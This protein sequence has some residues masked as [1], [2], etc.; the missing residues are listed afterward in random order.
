DPD[1]KKR[2]KEI[3]DE[4]A[5]QQ[6]RVDQSA[7]ASAKQKQSTEQKA[8][9]DSER[10]LRQATRDKERAD[11]EDRRRQEKA[12]QYRLGLQLKAA[13]S[14]KK[15]RL[16]VAK[17]REHE[18][19][20]ATMLFERSHGQMIMANDQMTERLTSA[21]ESIARM[22]RGFAMLGLIGEENTQKLINGLM[23]M[24]ASFDL[25][26]GGINAYTRLNRA[27][28]AYQASV[29]AAA[30]AESALAAA[31]S[32]TMVTSV[33]RGIAGP[34]GI[35]VASTAGGAVG[36]RVA[37]VGASATFSKLS[38]TASAAAG[39]MAT[40]PVAAIAAATSLLAVGAELV[41]F[42]RTGYFAGEKGTKALSERLEPGS[43]GRTATKGIF[44]NPMSPLG[45]VAAGAGGMGSLF[46]EQGLAGSEAKG[47][48]MGRE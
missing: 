4:A 14:E 10:L 48:R 45:F 28:R 22:G 20:Q 23:T 11:K 26:V 8:A 35:G 30:I 5:K 17:D 47:A 42:F 39:A 38:A 33:G 2:L 9:R 32:R 24:Q 40:I 18:T 15:L 21:T 36:G 7:V 16:Q 37:M 29:A 31:R 3:G 46:G 34:V 41:A 43:W 6:K 25:V 44:A 13:Q 12:A 1:S 27:V 19:T